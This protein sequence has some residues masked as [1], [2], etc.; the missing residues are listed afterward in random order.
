MLIENVLHN[1]A[2]IVF[3]ICVL[4]Y[5]ALNSGKPVYLRDKLDKCTTELGV[6]IRHSHDP[7]D[8]VNQ[9]WTKE[10]LTRSFKYNAPK[11]FNNLPKSVKDSENLQVFK[12]RLKTYLCNECY[13]L[14]AKTVTATYYIYQH[15]S[16]TEWSGGTP[17]SGY[18]TLNTVNK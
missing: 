11:L 6:S 7:I 8:S 5:I 14:D 1:I 17:Q 12:K 15:I 2:R 3:G 9:E 18:W 13:D 4:T 10:I 16:Q